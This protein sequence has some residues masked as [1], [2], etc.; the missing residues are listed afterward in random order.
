MN[1]SGCEKLVRAR[2]IAAIQSATGGRV[3]IAGFHWRPLDLEAEADGLV[4]H[5]REGSNE[6]P[7]AKID[8]LRVQISVLGFLQPAHPAA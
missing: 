3:E 6:A 5:G 8:R 7:Y 4:L 1:S 2:L